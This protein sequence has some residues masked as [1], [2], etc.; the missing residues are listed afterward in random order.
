MLLRAYPEAHED[1]HSRRLASKMTIETHLGH[2]VGADY[3]KF[4]ASQTIRLARMFG[5]AS[6]NSGFRSKTLRE[7]NS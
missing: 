1:F 6:F 5:Q 4:T 7:I 3:F 2:G